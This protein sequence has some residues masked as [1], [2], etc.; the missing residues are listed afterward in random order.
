MRP[1]Q[2][3]DVP[4]ELALLYDFVN[5]VDLRSYLEHGVAHATSDELE[6]SSQFDAW[7]R[8]HRLANPPSRTIHRQALQLRSVLRE[9]LKLSPEA[10]VGSAVGVELNQLSGDFP[11]IVSL[12][13]GVPNLQPGE[14]V[15][16]LAEVL[17]QLHTL[18]VTHQLDRL[19]MC[20]SDE[21][22]WIFFDRSKP[23]N[24]RWCSSDRCGNREKTRAY[25]QRLR[26]E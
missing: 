9:F 10:R 11:L 6:S 20:S 13:D 15:S 21:C 26:Q 2:R 5:S 25:R 24:R 17:A 14:H 12:D 19:K 18:A 8:L 7:M 16:G 3:Y 23:S 22:G 4:G 1:S